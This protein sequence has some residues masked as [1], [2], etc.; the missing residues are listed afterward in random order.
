MRPLVVMLGLVGAAI[1]PF[2]CSAQ[3]LDNPFAQ[4]FQRDVRIAPDGGNA[5]DSNAAIHTIDPWPP[6]ARNTRIPGYGRESASAVGQLYSNPHPFSSGGGATGG[7]SSQTIN[8]G[9]S[10]GTS[11]SSGY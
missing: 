11:G 9:S 2:E 8:I 3:V 7:P 10:A 6:Y 4:Y 5:N 1:L